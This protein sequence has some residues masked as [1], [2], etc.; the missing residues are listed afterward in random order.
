MQVQH[1]SCLVPFTFFVQKKT[2]MCRNETHRLQYSPIDMTS[3]KPLY[4]LR[5]LHDG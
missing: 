1:K 4:M 3:M 5:D 2:I